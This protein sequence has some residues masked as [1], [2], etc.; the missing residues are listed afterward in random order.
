MGTHLPWPQT[1]SIRTCGYALGAQGGASRV[2]EHGRCVQ[3]WAGM[4]KPN[5]A[6]GQSASRHA[7]TYNMFTPARG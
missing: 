2:V 7:Y 3:T 5:A 6:I 4:C 1:W